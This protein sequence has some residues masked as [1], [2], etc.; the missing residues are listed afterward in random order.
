MTVATQ[1][2]KRS[3][4]GTEDLSPID[5]IAANIWNREEGVD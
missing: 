2:R 1:E 5:V 4:E 3:V